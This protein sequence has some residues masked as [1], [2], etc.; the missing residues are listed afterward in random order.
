MTSRQRDAD[1]LNA[2]Q[3]DHFP[4]CPSCGDLMGLLATRCASCGASLLPTELD[5]AACGRVGSRAYR[6]ARRAK[7][8]REDAEARKG[9]GS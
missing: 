5:L 7:Q 6:E 3:L 8:L 1:R 2:V 4:A 9:T